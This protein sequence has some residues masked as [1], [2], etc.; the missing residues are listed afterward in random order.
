MSEITTQVG[1]FNTVSTTGFEGCIPTLITT[2]AGSGQLNQLI[3]ITMDR[4]RKQLSGIFRTTSVQSYRND[5]SFKYLLPTESKYI[6]SLLEGMKHFLAQNLYLIPD[7]LK[8]LSKLDRNIYYVWVIIPG[9]NMDLQDKVYEVEDKLIGMFPEFEFDFYTIYS[10][11]R[12][13]DKLIDKRF[14]IDKQM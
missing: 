3:N 10:N 11:G 1:E 6:S 4:R 8:V 9:R 13:P 12:D 5:L 7:V 2:E 14:T